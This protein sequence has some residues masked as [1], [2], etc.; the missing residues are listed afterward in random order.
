MFVRRKP[1]PA[2]SWDRA[3]QSLNP[4]VGMATRRR[5]RHK[6][7]RRNDCHSP[8]FAALLQPRLARRG[9]SVRDGP[10]DDNTKNRPLQRTDPFTNGM[11]AWVVPVLLL[12]PRL[13]RHGQRVRD[14]LAVDDTKTPSL[15]V[16]AFHQS[17]C[18][19]GSTFSFQACNHKHWRASL[20]NWIKF[21]IYKIH[22]RYRWRKK[23]N[24][25]V[26]SFIDQMKPS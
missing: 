6:H 4:V 7:E 13:A 21:R 8:A 5:K 15:F 20:R 11:R 22:V 10:I 2:S 19:F 1:A 9:Q 12:Q 24:W 26:H 3:R 23:T 14:G 25:P 16:G 18:F 17:A